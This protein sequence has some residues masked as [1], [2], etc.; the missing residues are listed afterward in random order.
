MVEKYVHSNDWKK[1]GLLL[2]TVW[3]LWTFDVL[4]SLTGLLITLAVFTAVVFREYIVEKKMRICLLSEHVCIDTH[5]KCLE[6]FHK[7]KWETLFLWVGGIAALKIGAMFDVILFSSGMSTVLFVS[8]I[9]Y[10]FLPEMK[11]YYEYFVS[12]NPDVL[13]TEDYEEVELGLMSSIYNARAIFAG[14][15]TAIFIFSLSVKQLTDPIQSVL[16]YII[17]IAIIYYT[18]RVVHSTEFNSTIFSRY[19]NHH[20]HIHSI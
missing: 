8:G 11:E 10:L 16:A 14:S 5:E 20:Q 6:H 17:I 9:I 12:H 3:G 1:F 2:G 15:I 7:M 19:H 18:Y 4:D 13:M